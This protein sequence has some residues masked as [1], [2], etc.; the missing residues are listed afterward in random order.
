ML[1]VVCSLYDTGTPVASAQQ[2]GECTALMIAVAEARLSLP[3]R[4]VHLMH[5]SQPHFVVV[6]RTVPYPLLFLCRA[7]D[8]TFH[9]TSTFYV[10]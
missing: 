4:T 8:C 2:R 7:R 9:H 5:P 1:D 3:G 10:Y 6:A